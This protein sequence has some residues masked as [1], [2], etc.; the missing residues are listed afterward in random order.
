MKHVYWVL[1]TTIKPCSLYGWLVLI[2]IFF[3][4]PT[5]KSRDGEPHGE[6]SPELGL[7]LPCRSRVKNA[8]WIENPSHQVSASQLTGARG[9]PRLLLSSDTAQSFSNSSCTSLRPSPY[10]A[11]YSPQYCQ[12]DKCHLDCHMGMSSRKTQGIY[13]SAQGRTDCYHTSKL[14]S[15]CQMP[16]IPH[17]RLA[18]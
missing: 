3:D 1:L 12:N 16:I 18:S 5:R 13:P 7:S 6:L 2:L 14:F 9:Q 11:F 15:P 10:P 17:Y 8:W 4:D